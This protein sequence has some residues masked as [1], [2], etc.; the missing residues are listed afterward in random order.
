MGNYLT[1]LNINWQ[2]ITSTDWGIA[3]TEEPT[4]TFAPA[5]LSAWQAER[6]ATP[7]LLN[8]ASLYLLKGA[9]YVRRDT[10]L[11]V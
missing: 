7:A 10:A 2:T 11:P 3:M 6:T 4:S 8:A 1:I 9:T 5:I